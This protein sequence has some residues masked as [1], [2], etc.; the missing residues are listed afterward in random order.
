MY[1]FQL[2]LSS[3]PSLLSTRQN[4]KEIMEIIARRGS[5][6]VILQKRFYHITMGANLK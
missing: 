4:K 1:P 5:T 6:M 2:F 3:I